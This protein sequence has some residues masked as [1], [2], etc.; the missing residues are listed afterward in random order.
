MKRYTADFETCTWLEDETYVWAWAI[1]DIDNPDNK[2]IGTDISDF[3]EFCKKSNN[4]TFLFHNLKFDGEFVIYWLL[5]NGFEYVSDKTKVRNKTFVT[6]INDMGVFYAIEIYW[7]KEKH[8]VVKAT[9]YD[10]LKI[11]PFSVDETAKYFNLPISKL[12]IDYNAYRE[13]E[14]ILTQEEEAY[15]CND[16]EIMARALHVVYS[17]GLTK[18]TRAGNA[19]YDFKTIM[20]SKDKF[21]HYF[22]KLDYKVDKEIRKC[23]KGGFT[24]LNPI[25]E[26]KEVENVNVLDVNSLYPSVMAC[27]RGELMPYG[28]PLYFEGKYKVDP[29]YPLYIQC[30]SCSFKI[31]KNMIPTVQIKNKKFFFTPNEYLESSGDEEVILTMTNIDL[32]IFLNHYDT[33]DLKY[34]DG[35]KFK[36]CNFLFKEYIDKWTQKKI[37]AGKAGNKGQRQ[38]AKLMLNSLYGKFATSLEMKS[39]RPVLHEDGIVRYELNDPEITDGMYLPVGSFITSYARKVTIETS[40]AIKSYSIEKYGKDM[41]IY[42]DTDSIHTTLP[43][44]ELKQFC[45]IDDFELGKWAH[46]AFATKGKFIRQKCYVEVIDG[47]IKITCAGMPKKCVYYHYDE[48]GKKIDNTLYY[49]DS[50]GKEHEFFI[51]DFQAGFTCSGK[52]TFSH[53]KGG[54][55]LIETDYTIK[56]EK[57]LA[58]IS[59]ML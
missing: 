41:Y 25:Y 24:Y 22:P 26:N 46:E 18:M 28:E 58:D 52:L 15:I 53:V 21:E 9:I 45:E 27:V 29:V 44:E 32:E 17:E 51:S 39:K 2:Y 14:H 6:L 20:G 12:K 16:V 55:K 57:L 50:I 59:K 31:K 37:E 56:E 54:V 35:W 10:S 40:Q 8:K 30:I 36:G 43:I 19:M 42:S 1:C 3:I 11:I 49:K 4:S 5:L 23:Y 33:F 7:K 47:E 38:L 34:L 13:R 48:N